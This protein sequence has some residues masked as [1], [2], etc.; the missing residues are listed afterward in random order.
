[1]PTPT[2]VVW[3]RSEHTAA[4]HDLLRR[5]FLAWLPILFKTHGRCVYAEGFAG[6]GV[7]DRGEA[8]SPVIAL[9][10][11]AAH[12]DLLAGMPHKRVDLLFVEEMPVGIS[13]SSRSSI[14][15][16]R[17]SPRFRRTRWFIRRL[18]ATALTSSRNC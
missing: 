12:R 9:E 7:Y 18:A 2:G 13:A 3:R 17:G 5:Y 1:M 14:G 10:V 16:A 8:G 11:V 4:K 15:P 6:P